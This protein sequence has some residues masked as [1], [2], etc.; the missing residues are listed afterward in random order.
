MYIV[1]S[2]DEGARIERK[3]D[4]P[5]T[6]AQMRW[7]GVAEGQAVL[8]LG[9]AAGTTTRILGDVVGPTGR[10]LG[11]D[12]S[13]ARTDE[14]RAHPHHRPW[15]EYRAGT[16]EQIPAADGEFDVAW[17]RFLFEYV[18]HPADAMR[19]M[20]RV[21]RRGGV[22]AV[23]DLDG[24]CVWHD[25]MPDDFAREM[26]AALET[27]RPHGFDPYVGRRL[28]GLAK[29]AGLSDIRIDVQPYHVLAGRIDDE[30]YAQWEMKIR[31]VTDTL[32]SLGW[33]RERASDL[34]ERFMAHLRDEDTFTYSTLISVSGIVPIQDGPA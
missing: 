19:E 2:V 1:E 5:E 30:R 22:V 14:A 20:V 31:A 29:E 33:T 26:S 11:V 21:T 16:A 27:L 6:A 32:A 13:V 9:C 18:R 10:V 17:S 25:P 34:F 7:A 28:F 4:V 24:N 15:I 8:D 12:A 3:T 23:A